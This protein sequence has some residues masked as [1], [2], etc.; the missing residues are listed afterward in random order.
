MPTAS[1]R[2]VAEPLPH[3]VRQ[4]RE[5]NL[6]GMLREHDGRGCNSWRNRQRK[7]FY[8]QYVCTHV[9]ALSGNG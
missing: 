2:R 5:K 6:L 4:K 9:G 7:E 3:R 8:E 1:A